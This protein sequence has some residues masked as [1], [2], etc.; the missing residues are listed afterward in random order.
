[1][2]LNA[3]PPSCFLLLEPNLASRHS[4]V[5]VRVGTRSYLNS[6]R[7]QKIEPASPGL[8]QSRARQE[9]PLSGLLWHWTSFL[10]VCIHTFF[11]LFIPQCALSIYNALY[12]NSVWTPEWT[13]QM[14]SPPSWSGKTWK[15]MCLTLWCGRLWD[16]E[17]SELWGHR[18]ERKTP[19]MGTLDATE[20][21]EAG[22][23][24]SGSPQRIINPVGW[25]FTDHRYCYQEHSGPRKY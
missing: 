23:R 6:N 13:E 4:E 5:T 21:G 19:K 1:M 10:N 14:W 8:P 3:Q 2:F 22:D 16:T 11:C 7:P 9:M 24:T 25:C 15:G 12:R 17:N 18:A 20:D